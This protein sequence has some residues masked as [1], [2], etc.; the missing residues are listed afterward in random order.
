MPF[1]DILGQDLAVNCLQRSLGRGRI[2]HAYL[3]AGPEGVGKEK[4]ALALAQALNCPASSPDPCGTCS[5]CRRIAAGSYPDVQRVAPAGNSTKIDQIRALRQE[6]YYRPLEGRRKV[7]IIT[8]AHKMTEQAAN[9]FLRLLEE[10]PLYALFL[11]LTSQQAGLLPTIISRCQVVPFYPL[12]PALIRD[13]L[14]R[15]LGLTRERAG[16]LAVLAG[17]SWEKARELAS[18]DEAGS[19]RRQVLDLVSLLWDGDQAARWLEGGELEKAQELPQVLEQLRLW[20]RDLLVLK[21]TGERELLFNQDQVAL[22]AEREQGYSTRRLIAA[23]EA[24][25][26]AQGL[27]AGNANTRLVLDVFL[28]RLLPDRPLAARRR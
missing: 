15:E 9:S 2:G 21:L 26:E 10:P 20:F 19:L 8:E 14:Q 23:L 28:G 6:A 18:S 24:L 17:G 4:T 16:V 25:R 12:S 1:A 3:F 5:T 7:Y 22:L 11:L 27:L 13:K